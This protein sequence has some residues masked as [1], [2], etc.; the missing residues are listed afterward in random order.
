MANRITNGGRAGYQFLPGTKII[1]SLLFADDIALIAKTPAGLQNQINNF[2]NAS[3]NLGLTVNLDKTKVMVFRKGGYLGSR[4]KWFLGREKL[5][6]VN[7]YKYLGYTLTT[8]LSIDI[9]LREYAGKAKGKVL[10]IFK[11]L[12]RLGQIDIDIFFK[13]FDAQVKPMLLYAAEI[14]G[15]SHFDTIEK[16][17]TFACKKLL[18][19]STRTPNTL[20]YGEVGRYPLYIDSIIRALN[21]WYKL[22][23]LEDNRL[24]KLAYIREK[25][26]MTKT[27][28]WAT[29]LKRCL[30]QNGYADRWIYEN[31]NNMNSF[32][33]RFKQRLIDCFKQNWHDKLM[34]SDRFASYR[35]FK[36]THQREDYLKYIQIAKFRKTLSRLRLGI[37]ELHVN[38]RFLNPEATTECPFCA[39]QESEIHFLLNCP[40]Y[41][42]LRAKYISKYWITLN[43]VSLYDLLQNPNEDITK[44]VAMFSFYALKFREQQI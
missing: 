14:W 23:Q 17:H 24:P 36:N 21:Y 34:N 40:S 29:N 39:N 2:K 25:Q 10:N 32:I 43:N 27:Q 19:V 42:N 8:K 28:G 31:T 1:Y 13:L 33:K 15:T 26:E 38:N 9:P 35:I 22:L 3:E 16:V 5:E 12:F 18:G 4:E 20:I 7:N 30:E 41:N 11:T 6:V 37:V 44:G